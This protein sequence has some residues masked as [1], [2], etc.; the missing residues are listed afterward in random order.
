MNNQTGHGGDDRPPTF[1]AQNGGAQRSLRL[2]EILVP[3]ALSV[4]LPQTPLFRL[5][6]RSVI[7]QLG[8]V[9]QRPQP[10]RVLLV[11]KREDGRL[12]LEVVQSDEDGVWR[13]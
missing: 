6:T 7:R 5:S 13:T 12:V 8:R 10:G 1:L 11:R 9:E 2:H 3:Y 4:L